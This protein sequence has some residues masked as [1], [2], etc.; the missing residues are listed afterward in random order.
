MTQQYDYSKVYFEIMTGGW[1]RISYNLIASFAR[2][3]LKRFS[4]STVLDLGCGNG[5]Y[6]SVLT[7]GG[8]QLYG[9]DIAPVSVQ[10]C[11]AAGYH[12]VIQSHAEKLD[13]DSEKF[14][15]VFTSEVIEHIDDYRQMLKEIHRVLKPG[16]GLVLTTTCYSTSIYQFLLHREGGTKELLLNLNRYLKG[17]WNEEERRAFIR[18]WCFESLGG[19][20]HGFTTKGLA[21]EI[22]NCGF[23]IVICKIFYVINPLPLFE[24]YNLQSVLKSNRVLVKKLILLG[25]V[26]I[27]PLLNIL[28]K[29]LKLL[30]NNLLIIAQ[31]R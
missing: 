21:S 9:I 28:L 3:G 7:E 17:Y 30:A 14:D 31:K 29:S 11:K 25:G 16:G 18:Q 15:M 6:G 2:E 1:N 5:I 13:I 22:N 8:A 4:P 12:Q 24:N 19:H 23:D 27:A 26:L 20:C 10:L